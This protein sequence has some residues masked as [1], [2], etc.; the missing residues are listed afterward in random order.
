MSA[1]RV[2]VVGESLHGAPRPL[3]LEAI[4]AARLVGDARQ[5][6]VVVAVFAREVGDLTGQFASV[7]GVDRVVVVEHDALAPFLAG[8]WVGA[9]SDVARQL[10]P[11]LTLVPSSITGRDY[12]ARV[13]ARLG[14]AMASD[15]LAIDAAGDGLVVT[16]AVLGARTRTDVT[17]APGVP[18]MVTVAPGAFK[19]PPAS[20]RSAPIE[21]MSVAIAERDCRVRL[22]ST[23]DHQGGA[24]GITKAERIVS[25]GRGLGKPENFALVEDLAAAMKAAVGASGATVGMGWRPHADQVGSTGHAVSPAL[26]LA[27]GISGAPQHLVGMAGAEWVVAINRDPQAP[28]FTVADFGIVGDLFE[29]VPALTRR[30]KG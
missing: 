16:R 3:S 12:A 4:A 11:F 24:Q 13:A 1:N 28:I 18:G 25:G 5:A 22:V 19:A 9:V 10:D 29:V 23:T 21:A 20:D 14:Y 7:A 8:P 27:V 15:V 2:L 30:L 26:Y 6:E 17:F